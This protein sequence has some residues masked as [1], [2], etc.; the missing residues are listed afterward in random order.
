MNL[1]WYDKII[2]Y[3]VFGLGF[4]RPSYKDP[5]PILSGP[6]VAGMSSISSVVFGVHVGP[7]I[8]LELNK[9]MFFGAAITY[10]NMFGSTNVLAN[11]SQLYLGG[12]YTSFF[13]HLGATF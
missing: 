8:D 10:H 7:G 9:N 2:P 4:Y 1:S 12:A 13:L 3:I 5:T 11:G 6:A